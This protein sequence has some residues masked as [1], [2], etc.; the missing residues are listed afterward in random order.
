[1]CFADGLDE[2]E[3]KKFSMPAPSESTSLGESLLTLGLVSKER[4]DELMQ[5]VGR[6]YLSPGFPCWMVCCLN[7]R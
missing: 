7:P 4:L 2:K 1:M 5:L 3:G 6:P